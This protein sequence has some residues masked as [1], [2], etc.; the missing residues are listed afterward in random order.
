MTTCTQCSAP[1][2]ITNDD[3]AFYEKVSPVLAGKKYLIPPPTLCPPCRAQRRL[4]FRNERCLYHRKSDLSGKQIITMYAANTPFKV[5]DQKEWWG[6]G[7]DGLTF[8][9]EV[10]WSRPFFDQFKE[11]LFAA[12][13]ISMINK[14]HQNS[15]YSN[16]ALWNKNSYMLFT[17]GGCE[18]S[19]YSNR[20]TRSKNICDCSSAID[21]EL[22][23]EIVDCNKCYACAWMQNCEGCHDCVLGYDLRSCKNCFACFGLQNAQYCIGNKKVSKEEYERLLPGL[24]AN[25]ADM[26][27][28]FEKHK[29]ELPRKYMHGFGNEGCT[30][31]AIQHSKNARECYEVSEVQDCTFVSNVTSIKDA[32]DVNNDDNSELVYEAV[33][34]ESNSMHCFND[35][36]WFDRD[37]L[38]SNLCFHSK[39][40]F[41]C[42][43]LKHKQYCILNKQY[44]KEEYEALVP[45]IIEHMKQTSEWGEFFTPTI[46]PFGFN[47]TVGM[48]NYALTKE[49]ALKRGWKWTD[50]DESREKYLGPAV[51]IPSRIEDTDDVIC[52]KILTCE[53]TGR[54]YKIIPQE[55][56]LYRT[57]KIPIPHKCPEQRH[58]ERMA[59]RNPRKLW[60]RTCMKCNTAIQTT[61]AP[62]RPEK[63]Y[64][65]ECYL[66][67]VY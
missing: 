49:E 21:C 28:K 6:D 9:R 65:E 14:E 58:K 10:D 53:V 62:D 15:E 37:V 12:P 26:K 8:G 25:F 11:L 2:K 46:S 52:Q 20:S 41:G 19:F 33:G 56:A 40:L 27:A 24:R 36:C 61:Y 13:K 31:N 50:E 1:F 45:K 35:I 34:S 32:Y 48:E 63:I 43:S 60:S 47:E 30:G 7:W 38:Y 55:L 4:A 64:C 42:C 23:Y 5:Y 51:D 29:V 22:C 44:S 16:F 3:L 18:D 17:S 57:M 59:M 67:E 54:A 66:K 39:N